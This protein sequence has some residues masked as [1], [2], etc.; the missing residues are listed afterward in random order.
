MC[1]PWVPSAV[2]KK[3]ERKGKWEAAFLPVAENAGAGGSGPWVDEGRWADTAEGQGSMAFSLRRA[4]C[5]IKALR[6]IVWAKLWKGHGL[7]GLCVPIA[8]A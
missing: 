1:K 4:P 7:W 3:R 5:C 8:Q 2:L 6:V